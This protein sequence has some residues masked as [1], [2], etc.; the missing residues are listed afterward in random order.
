MT[1]LLQRCL[2]RISGAVTF[3]VLPLR[4][5]QNFASLSKNQRHNFQESPIVWPLCFPRVL[6]C[7]NRQRALDNS[8]LR[9]SQNFF[10]TTHWQRKYITMLFFCRHANSV[11]CL[12][13]PHF[14]P[15]ILHVSKLSQAEGHV[16]PH[17]RVR[18]NP[19]L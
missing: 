14:D 4:L 5:I 3:L 17:P 19:N 12:I 8:T 15:R 10:Y 13:S 9:M 11:S 1:T 16:S 7:V 18:L 2:R 6:L